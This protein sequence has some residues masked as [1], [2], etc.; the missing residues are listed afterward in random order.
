MDETQPGMPRPYYAGHARTEFLVA[1]ATRSVGEVT[2]SPE[3]D[4]NP[5][6][7]SIRPLPG[8]ELPPV[9]SSPQQPRRPSLSAANGGP[10][11]QPSGP[12]SPT[13]P[14]GGLPPV[15]QSDFS[16]SQFMASDQPP[17]FPNPSISEFGS[18]S[19]PP[20]NQPSSFSVAEREKPTS[21][22]GGRFATFP[23]KALGPRP[24][25]GVGSSFSTNP[26]ISSPPMQESDRAPSIEIDRGGHDESFSSSVAQALSH[27]LDG[28]SSVA[29]PSST[30]A[31]AP[32][33][34]KDGADF[35]P[36]RYSPPPPVYTPSNGQGLPIGA[37]PSQP[38]SAMQSGPGM[39]DVGNGKAPLVEEDE[40]ED[41]LAYMSPRLS[42]SHESLPDVGDRR[43]RFGGVSDVEQELEKR[44]QEQDQIQASPPRVAPGGS[45][46]V[47]VPALEAHLDAASGG[48]VSPEGMLCSP[49]SLC[50]VLIIA[51]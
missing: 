28:S 46:R 11:G 7:R 40:E 25:P 30:Q 17:Q 45:H 13:T 42:A 38:P 23:V 3:P 8:S 31:A 49:Q 47:P 15:E 51:G 29:G 1:E 16:I 20:L 36:Q 19:S 48:R 2:F 27:S 24:Q 21:P 26:Y 6:H 41:V 33:D 32:R 34:V 35:G 50:H 12:T 9:L 14:Y 44:H 22:R 37:A 43:V 5:A 39:L 18:F 10:F 4:P